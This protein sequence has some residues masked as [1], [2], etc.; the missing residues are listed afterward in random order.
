MSAGGRCEFMAE[1][2]AC[3]GHFPGAPILP[4]ALLL[5]EILR[6]LPLVGVPLQVASVKFRRVVTPGTRVELEYVDDAGRCRF[7]LRAGGQ[8]V[9]D[10]VVS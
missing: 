1:S 10:G 2:P 8:V 7:L 3:E 4:G 6:R 5:D 9:V